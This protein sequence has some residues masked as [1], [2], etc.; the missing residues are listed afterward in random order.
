M[1]P[2]PDSPLARLF[3]AVWPTAAVRARLAAYRDAWR[4]PPASRLVVDANLH[5]TLHFIGSFERARLAALGAR[6]AAVPSR[7]AVLRATAPAIWRGGIAVLTLQ[8]DAALAALHAE[9]G[10]A[11]V[12]LG[13]VLEARPFAPHVTLARKA[14]RSEPPAELP[15][16]GWRAS[17]FALAE[18]RSGP[19]SDYAIVMRWDEAD[20]AQ[21][22]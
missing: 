19:P 22:P 1:S 2:R 17:G 4:W 15:E 16:L 7:P 12:E 21:T 3:I 11:L 14:P 20:L 10:I 18:T 8:G 5:A 9:V 13:I 6:L